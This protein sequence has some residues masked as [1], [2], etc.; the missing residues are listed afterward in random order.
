MGL[1]NWVNSIKIAYT[2]LGS[3]EVKPTEKELELRKLARRSIIA[4]CDIEKGEK[5]NKNNIGLRRPGNGL[6]PKLIDQ[7][8]GLNATR[9]ILK[10][11][12]IKFSD[13]EN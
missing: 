2:L 7:I 5:F 4:L 8:Y 10:G 6:S 9:K 3:N 11:T 1:K 13:F 12:L